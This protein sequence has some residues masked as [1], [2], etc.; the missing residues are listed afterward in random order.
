[1]I[2]VKIQ[3]GCGQHYAFDVEPVAGRMPTAVACPA[4]GGDGTAAANAIIAEGLAAPPASAA[5]PAAR[6][7]LRAAVAAPTVHPVNPI[8]PA[9][10]RGSALL[11]GQLDRTKAE[12]E[13]RS[14]IFWGDPPEEVVKFLMLHGISPQEATVLV[15]T[16]FQERAATIRGTGIRK[17]VV[18]SGLVS[19]P[20]VA[21]I[22]FA[23]VGVIPL[24]I[25]ACTVVV[26]LWGAWMILKGVF[27]VLAPKSEPGDVADH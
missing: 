10:P 19:V 12:G 1:M 26:G 22:V 14:K 9:T 6:V 24:K 4:C 20:I 15:R 27:M 18:G 11:P 21:F 13:A 2:T 7:R 23:A 5:A 17:I 8:A 3:C 16:M 25:F